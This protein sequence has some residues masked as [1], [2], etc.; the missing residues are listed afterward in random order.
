VRANV[1]VLCV[2]TLFLLTLT[3]KKTGVPV[4]NDEGVLVDMYCDADVLQLPDL[5]LDINVGLALEQVHAFEHTH[6][7]THTHTH[8]LTLSLSH[9][10]T[11][12]SLYAVLMWN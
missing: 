4:L 1:C 8:S 10:H 2:C 5:D 6:T 11:H 7:H 12:C 9:T 3:T